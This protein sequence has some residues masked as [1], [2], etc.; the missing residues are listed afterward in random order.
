MKKYLLLILLFIPFTVFA[1][2]ARN[3]SLNAKYYDNEN[4]LIMLND[5][6]YDSYTTI[7]KGNTL[8]IK[9]EIEIKHIYIIY[10]INSSKGKLT[11]EKESIELG[12]NGFIHEYHK[13]SAPVNTLK[14]TFN[15]NVTISEIQVYSEGEIPGDVQIWKKE[16]T[17]DLMVFSTHADDEV[18]FFAGLIPTYI[19]RGKKVHV[20]YL[21]RHD[22]GKHKNQS[23]M[24][25]QL[26]GLWTLG[27]TDYPTFGYIPDAYSK[28]TENTPK[29]KEKI[30]K[31]V[32]KQLE[33][34]DITDEDIINF[35]ISVMRQYKPKVI[36]MH[37]EYGEYGHG[38]HIL[39]TLLLE[40][41]IKKVNTKDYKL[42]KAYI[43]LYDKDNWTTIDLDLPLEYYGGKTAYQKSKEAFLK[44]QSQQ[45][46]KYPAW[47]NGE[48]DEYNTAK[49]IKE[50]SPMYWGLYYTVVGKDKNKNDLF[51]N[52]PEEKNKEKTT[53][54]TTTLTTKVPTTTQETTTKRVD[55]LEET[56][57]G[58]NVKYILGLT[59]ILILIVLLLIIFLN[60]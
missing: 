6:S 29:E 50:Y 21:A 25:E 52:I 47:L 18:L 43:H 15:N 44:H 24:H 45:F 53:K 34:A 55:P 16:K 7:N 19:D 14:L 51:E 35:D 5:N 40:E 39:N 56:N 1:E 31:T 3:I 4:E 41:A 11:T 17:S 33:D 60:I 46:S 8:T 28:I 38:Q 2:S 42:L 9:S 27:I 32:E 26:N 30:L 59:G 10:E 36:V 58:I 22:I 13:L 54:T 48:H 20:T 49:D 12:L 23:R 57:E 37:D